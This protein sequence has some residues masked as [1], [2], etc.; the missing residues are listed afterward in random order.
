MLTGRK[1]RVEF[2][3][4]QA[5][6]A[7][8]IGAICRSVWNTGLE[9][10]REYRRRGS[11]I[12]YH[13][14]AAQLAGAKNT[15]DWLKTAPSHVLQQ[16]LMDL[17]RACRQHGTFQ[18]RWRSGRAWSPSFRFPA[19]KQ[20]AVER[21]GKRWG[22]A[23]LPKLGWVRFR[24]SRSLGGMVR[25]ATVSRDGQ[26]WFVSFLVED[27]HTTPPQH[28]GTSAVGVDRGVKVAVAVSD[29]T[30]WD[31]QF[32]TRGEAVRYRR[33][34]QQLARQR[35]VSA[36]RKK[37]LAALRVIRRRERDRRADFCAW[38]SSRLATRHALVAL[39]DLRIHS[40][41]ASAK[42]TLEHPGSE[43][44]QKAGLNRSILDK[45]WY[46]FESALYGVARYTGAQVVKVPAAYTSLTCSG[47]RSVDPENRES[48]AVFRCTNC[49]HSGNADV[50]AAKNILYAAGHAVS[51][52]GDLGATRSAKQEPGGKTARRYHPTTV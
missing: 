45:G 50:N 37:T 29:G 6:F 10:R 2:T 3:H 47:C 21:L 11:W 15:H 38:T 41:T 16:T 24:W 42:G 25:S 51:A 32:R 35:K 18:V 46:A 13:E 17:D 48:Q 1:Y 27:G 52:C 33:L 7:E 5:E 43:V 26:R 40:M 19:G 23:K 8:T 22:R 20:I 34:Q 14:Q 9:Q 28:V 39:E 30:L 12:N 36:N 49:G 31:R 44:R 4:G